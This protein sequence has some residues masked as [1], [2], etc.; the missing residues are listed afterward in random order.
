MA[1]AELAI[2]VDEQDQVHAG[3]GRR[4]INARDAE[5]RNVTSRLAEALGCLE[6][7]H[8]L[9]LETRGDSP[10]Y[11]YYVQ[12]AAGGGEGFRVEAV[13]NRFL[14]GWQCLDSTA[15]RRLRRL[16]W[17]PPTDIGDGPANWWR[18]YPAG[19]PTTEMAELAVATLRKA[20]DVPRPAAL[21]YRAFSRD[22][23]EIL[24]PT[25]GVEHH[26]R[27]APLG[28]RVDAALRDYLEVDE[29][30]H[31]EDDDRPVR[32]GDAMVYVRV[33]SDRGFVA[34]FSPA[35]Q[36][37]TRSSALVEAVNDI[38]NSIRGA[39]AAVTDDAVMIAAE[40][41]DQPALD[42]AVINAFKAVSSLAN[43]CGAELQA[44][45]GGNT[46]FDQPAPPVEDRP[47]PGYGFYL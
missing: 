7:G 27:R 30:V 17:R 45:F 1:I 3:S 11:P 20:F 35:L 9:C 47:E 46:F 12:F 34:V 37:L 5:W 13:S 40:V 26:K 43:S 32:S 44:R 41:D 24:L 2:E 29:V 38:N 33:V 16:G 19:P 23:E 18:C 15:E 42:S 8:F 39:R 25:L 21:V 6:E 28:Q 10:C 4:R 31:D 22:G 14:S 36:G